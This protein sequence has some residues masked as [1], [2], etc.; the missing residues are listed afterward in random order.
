[1]SL[2]NAVKGGDLSR[3]VLLYDRLTP[4]RKRR[5]AKLNVEVIPPDNEQINQVFDWIGSKY[6][7]MPVTP[8]VIDE[9]ERE[10]ARLI[11]RIIKTKVTFVG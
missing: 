5:M 7:R 6:R 1:M 3:A 10:A 2:R 9:M 8:K 11:R 4:K